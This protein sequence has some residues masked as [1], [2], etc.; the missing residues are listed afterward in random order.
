LLGCAQSEPATITPPATDSPATADPPAVPTLSGLWVPSPKT[1]WQWQLNG[2]P[3][4][5]SVDVEMYDIDLFDND[6][7]TVAA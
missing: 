3:L 1:T 5:T 7:A 6:T 2:L 4:D